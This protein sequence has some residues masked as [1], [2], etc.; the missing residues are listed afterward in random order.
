M[1]SMSLLG[2]LFEITANNI[3]KG[4]HGDLGVLVLL[5]LRLGDFPRDLPEPE[6]G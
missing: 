3:G 2:T 5:E 6:T 4:I 1:S